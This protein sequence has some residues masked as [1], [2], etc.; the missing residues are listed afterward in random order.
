MLKLCK[1]KAAMGLSLRKPFISFTLLRNAQGRHRDMTS[2]SLGNAT[3]CEL[4]GDEIG[5]MGKGVTR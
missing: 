2:R 4:C 1:L 3:W 5:R